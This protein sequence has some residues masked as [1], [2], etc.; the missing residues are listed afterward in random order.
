LADRDSPA[1]TFDAI[2]RSNLADSV[3]VHD[4]SGNV[5]YPRILESPPEEKGESAAARELEFQKK[6]YTAA[7]EAYFRIAK[8]ALTFT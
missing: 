1:D 5:L 8:A 3:V 6:D 7:A 4:G 2:V